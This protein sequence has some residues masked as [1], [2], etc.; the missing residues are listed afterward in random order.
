MRPGEPGLLSSHCCAASEGSVPSFKSNSPAAVGFTD[1]MLGSGATL[2]SPPDALR[3]PLILPC[4]GICPL[5][6]KPASQ[7]IIEPKL[8]PLERAISVRVQQPRATGQQRAGIHCS[9]Q[10]EG[11]HR[12]LPSFWGT[13]GCSSK[14]S[15][16][17]SHSHTHTSPPLHTARYTHTWIHALHIPTHTHITYTPTHI[18]TCTL[19]YTHSN[20]TCV[21]KYTR[22]HRV[23]SHTHTHTHT[24]KH[25][26]TCTHA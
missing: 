9:A 2:L 4:P 15:G 26:L 23:L 25:T 6:D 16:V 8:T 19:E 7:V 22:A 17:H 20:F 13:H 10:N 3:S 5:T 24:Q 12:A 18:P 11:F 1:P 14:S 21:H